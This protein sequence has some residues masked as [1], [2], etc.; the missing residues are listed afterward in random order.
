MVRRLT[1]LL[2]NYSRYNA[3]IL[4]A[5]DSVFD[6]VFDSVAGRIFGDDVG[7]STICTEDENPKSCDNGESRK[8]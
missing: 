6:S 5:V 8:S 7:L 1:S 4:A 2:L 3:N